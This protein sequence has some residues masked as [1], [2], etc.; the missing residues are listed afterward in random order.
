M[1]NLKIL[2]I[3]LI[4][5]N[6]FLE[7]IDD[8]R[9]MENSDTY[10]MIKLSE[11]ILY[12]YKDG[13]L[14]RVYPISTSKYGVGPFD[15]SNRTPL[16]KHYVADKIGEDLKKG[17]ILKA[18]ESVNKIAE[19]L[20]EN[21]DSENDYLTSRI[22]WLKGTEPFKNKWFYFD[23]YKRYIYIHGTQEEGLIGKPASEGCIRMKNDD[24]IELYNLV[25]EGI[26]VYIEI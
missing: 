2:F 4:F 20:N 22:L 5:F 26:M 12:Y 18:R 16:G 21:Y 11:Q 10:I 17:S 19:I 9:C 24:V 25:F 8:S 15:G 7:K 23:S 3:F 1:I 14:E 13:L 6:F